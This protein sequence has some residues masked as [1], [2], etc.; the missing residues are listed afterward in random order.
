[1]DAKTQEKLLNKWLLENPLLTVGQAGKMLNEATIKARSIR[2][3]CS[4]SCTNIS[5]YSY[6]IFA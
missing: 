5:K 1:M 3:F 2:V 6:K 4:C